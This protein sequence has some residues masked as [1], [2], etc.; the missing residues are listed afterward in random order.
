M[1]GHPPP[2]LYDSLVV[3]TFLSFSHGFPQGCGLMLLRLECCLVDCFVYFLFRLGWGLGLFGFVWVFF[4][5]GN[6]LY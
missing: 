3:G 1:G 4:G 2:R 5:T 6:C